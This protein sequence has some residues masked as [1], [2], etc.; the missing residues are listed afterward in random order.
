[1]RLTGVAEELT[2]RFRPALLISLGAVGFVLL[3]ACINVAN[4][5]LARA[6]DR[7]HETAIR[8]A[9]GAGRGAM[10]RQFLTESLMLA[11]AGGAAGLALGWWSAKALVATFPERIPL[12]RVEQTRLDGVVLLFTIGIS[13]LTGL[14]IRTAAGAPGVALRMSTSG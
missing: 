3:I 14:H 5:L 4:L 7:G 1:M 2:S 9:L 12:P 6:S 13:L 8:L 11:A 10:I